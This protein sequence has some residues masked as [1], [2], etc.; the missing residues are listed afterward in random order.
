MSEQNKDK[1][2]N[3]KEFQKELHKLLDDLNAVMV[4]KL[5]STTKTSIQNAGFKVKP[6]L[7]DPWTVKSSLC[8]CFK[9]AEKIKTST[10]T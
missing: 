8:A 3:E 9:L 5:P 2:A 4:K 7:Y 1:A 10:E 6:Q